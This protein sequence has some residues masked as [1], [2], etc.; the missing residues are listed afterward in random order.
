VERKVLGR[1]DKEQELEEG[2]SSKEEGDRV[3]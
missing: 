2:L 1:K 3:E